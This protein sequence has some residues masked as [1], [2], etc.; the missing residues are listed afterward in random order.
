M[1]IHL[2]DQGGVE[3]P[4]ERLRDVDMQKLR[5]GQMHYLS[6]IDVDRS[7]HVAPL[8]LPIVHNELLGLVGVEG[9]VVL[10]TPHFQ[11]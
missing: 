6:Q 2:F 9:Q 5:T 3:G 1:L 8:G 4:G 10:S 11:F 7:V